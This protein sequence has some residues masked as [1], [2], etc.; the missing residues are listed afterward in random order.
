MIPM[1]VWLSQPAY[2]RCLRGRDLDHMSV[3]TARYACHV[4][5]SVDC[6]CCGSFQSPKNHKNGIELN[7][8]KQKTLRIVFH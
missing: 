4:A 3:S 1:W 6:H 2:Y 7:A 5:V 8:R